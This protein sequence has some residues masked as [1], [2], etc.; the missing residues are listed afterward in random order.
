MTGPIMPAASPH[1]STAS[2]VASGFAVS[3]VGML[4]ACGVAHLGAPAV[5]TGIVSTAPRGSPMG[6]TFASGASELGAGGLL[7]RPRTRRLGATLAVDVVMPPAKT[8]LEAWVL[9][10]FDLFDLFDCPA[11]AA[12]R[13]AA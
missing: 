6:L 7:L 4:F 12:H 9:D 2:A 13:S 3:R 11:V 8:R 5:F 10:L 1:D